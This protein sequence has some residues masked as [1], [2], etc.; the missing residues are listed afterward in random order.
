MKNAL[1]HY[2]TT[3]IGA[4]LAGLQAV[5]AYQHIGD[6]SLRELGLRFSVAAL[7]FLFGLW[8]HDPKTNA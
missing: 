5:S 1:Y 3:L 2:R 6:V 7:T 4:A 8:A